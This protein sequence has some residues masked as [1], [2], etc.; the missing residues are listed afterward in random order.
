MKLKQVD[1]PLRRRKGKQKGGKG[2]LGVKNK[3]MKLHDYLHPSSG[4]VMSG[5]G[6]A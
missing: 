5:G 2:S 1:E 6:G 4:Y 3:P